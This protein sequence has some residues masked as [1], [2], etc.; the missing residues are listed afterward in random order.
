MRK[1]CFCCNIGIG[2]GHLEQ[3][4][5]PCGDRLLCHQCNECMEKLGMMLLEGQGSHFKFL[6]KTGEVVGVRNTSPTFLE[7]VF[8][9]RI[10]AEHLAEGE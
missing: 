7:D 6:L 9:G 5:Y 1:E 8:A 3:V 2:K 10:K 4:G